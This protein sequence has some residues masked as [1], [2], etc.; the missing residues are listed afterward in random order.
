MFPFLL[1]S[2]R[3][4]V[5]EKMEMTMDLHAKSKRFS[6]PSILR[7]HFYFSV[8]SKIKDKEDKF[9]RKEGF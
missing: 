3:G 7:F 9:G 1:M 4:L 8:L 5:A 6:S 2:G